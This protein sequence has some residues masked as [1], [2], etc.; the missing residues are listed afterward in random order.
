VADPKAPSV[1]LSVN[2]TWNV[3]NF[4]SGLIRALQAAGFSV[5]VASP[6]DAYVQA[7]KALGVR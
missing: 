5:V 6:P 2:T 4:R 7:L 3:V 1:L